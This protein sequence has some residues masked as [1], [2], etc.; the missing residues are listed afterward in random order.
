MAEQWII[1]SRGALRVSARELYKSIKES[2]KKIL[3]HAED[4]HFANYRRKSP[5]SKSQ[6][7]KL[8]KIFNELDDN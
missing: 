4:Y 6:L 8:Q 5:W 1:F 2:E 3:L 7:E